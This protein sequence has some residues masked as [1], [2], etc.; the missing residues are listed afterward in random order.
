MRRCSS[1]VEVEAVV[2]WEAGSEARLSALLGW[3][4]KSESAVEGDVVS[5]SKSVRSG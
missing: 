1:D 3:A 2:D 5:L 4:G